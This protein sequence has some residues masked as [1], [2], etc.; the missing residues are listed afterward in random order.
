LN[1]HAFLSAVLEISFW[2]FAL[3]I[4]I[5][6]ICFPVIDKSDIRIMIEGLIANNSERVETITTVTKSN[7]IVACVNLFLSDLDIGTQE[8]TS[9]D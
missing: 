5:L 8:V 7:A 4:F 3:L 2:K 1:F 9:V 6:I